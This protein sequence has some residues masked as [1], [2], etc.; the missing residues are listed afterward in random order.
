MVRR[1]SLFRRLA[2]GAG[3]IAL[4]LAGV[5]IVLVALY[6]FAPPVSTLMLAR[7]IEGRGYE[8]IYAPLKTIA[9]VAVASVIASEDAQVLRERR[10]RLG[11]PA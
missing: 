6:A 2:R 10:R 3:V 9:P 5:F 7:S 11:R 4:A 1:R 8:R